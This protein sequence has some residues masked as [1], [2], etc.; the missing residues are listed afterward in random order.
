MI[1]FV[2]AILA[3]LGRIHSNKWALEDTKRAKE[4]YRHNNSEIID[5]IDC[6]MVKREWPDLPVLETVSISRHPAPERP[7]ILCVIMTFSIRHDAVRAVARTWGFRCSGFVAVSDEAD[8]SIPTVKTSY[9]GSEEWEH[10]WK[11]KISIYRDV[12]EFM[13]DGGPGEGVFDYVFFAD[14]DT[15]LIYENLE[16]FLLKDESPVRRVQAAGQGIYLGAPHRISGN[17]DDPDYEFLYNVGGAGTL[18]DPVA[19]GALIDAMDNG[20]CVAVNQNDA[21]RFT[22]EDVFTGL[23]LLGAVPDPIIPIDGRDAQG[24]HRFFHVNPVDILGLPTGQ[25]KTWLEWYQETSFEFVGGLEG[26]S[27]TLISFHDAKNEKRLLQVDSFLYGRCRPKQG[28]ET[29]L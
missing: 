14:D 13:L 15:Y 18:M 10:L 26:V 17:P 2:L 22:F 16:A 5:D 27:P 23:C 7:R 20:R 28:P 11:K 6:D 8:P 19:I 1:F 12:A 29:D 4:L 9:T 21:G 3:F 25:P 24:R